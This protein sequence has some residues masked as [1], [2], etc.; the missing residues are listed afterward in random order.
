MTAFDVRIAEIVDEAQDVRS[1]LLE[2]TDGA[3]FPAW[4]PG[5]HVDLAIRPDLIRQYSLCG[6]LTDARR[7]RVTVLRDPKSR[8]G[9]IA[10]H[11]DLKAGDIV[12][13]G[14]VRNNFPLV[15]AAEYRLIAGGVGITPFLPI[16]EQLNATGKPWQLLYGGRTRASM[17]FADALE[18]GGNVTVRP[19]DVYGLLDLAG[20]IGA[21]QPGKVVYC[22][23]PEPLLKAVE[24]TCAGWP[25][26]AVQIERF[27]PAEEINHS[28]DVSFEVELKHSGQVVTVAPGQSIADALEEI[29]VHIP[30][31]CNEGTCGTCITRLLEGTPDHRDSFLRPKQREEGKRIMACCSRALSPRLVLDL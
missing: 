27:R 13:L 18:S 11:D 28:G 8:G 1:L 6:A 15:D 17:A 21:Y 22:C 30:R 19:E 23:G 14:E 12:R 26:E 4:Q 5:A 29:N 31:S 16:I 3:D 9:S 20:F 2:R 24:A 25:E 10:I 7:W